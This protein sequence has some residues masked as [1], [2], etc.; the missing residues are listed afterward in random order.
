MYNLDFGS[1]DIFRDSFRS[2][3]QVWI[4]LGQNYL[5]SDFSKNL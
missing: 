4:L 5:G 2:S 3:R 1:V